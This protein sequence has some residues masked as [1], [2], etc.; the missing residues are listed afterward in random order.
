MAILF[1]ADF[2]GNK[3]DEFIEVSPKKLRKKV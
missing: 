1:S 2:H 3:N